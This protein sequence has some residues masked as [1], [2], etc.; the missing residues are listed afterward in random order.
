MLSVMG[1]SKGTDRPIV[2]V[3]SQELGE[4]AKSKYPGKTS[5]IPASYVKALEAS[6]ARVVPILIQQSEDYYKH[7]MSSINGVVFPGG[8]VHFADP[9]G[10]AA[11][12]KIIIDITEQL[13]DSGVSFPILGVCQGYQLLMYIASNSTAEEEIL[14]SCDTANIALPL[15]FKPG[16]QQSRLYEHASKDIIDTLKTLPVTSNHHVLCVTEDMLMTHNLEHSWRVLSTNKDS[17]GLEFISS[18]EHFHRPIV[19][20]QFHPEKN[21]FEWKPGQANPHSHKAILSARHFYDWVVAESR[22]NNQSF[23]SV[24]EEIDSLMYNYSPVYT[25]RIGGYVEQI[26]YF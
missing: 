9:D 24:Q 8:G 5:F 21:M 2:G 17:Q 15:D 10:Y 6:G 11:A 19:G 26:Y 16:F 25:G 3:L 1:E 13:Q 14:V 23:S 18:S 12:G 22:A 4:E 7:I 20:L